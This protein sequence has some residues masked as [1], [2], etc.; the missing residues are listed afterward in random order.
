MYAIIELG[1]KQYRVAKGDSILVEAPKSGELK[2]RVLMFVDGDKVT[3]D[4][5]TLGKVTVGVR[6]DGIERERLNRVMKFRPKQ[7]GTSKKTIGHRR[8]RTRVSITDLSA[9]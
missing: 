4:T 3:T 9:K 5:A 2:P 8:T 1:G 7:G 6:A